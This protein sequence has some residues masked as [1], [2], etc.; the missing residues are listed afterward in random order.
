MLALPAAAQEIVPTNEPSLEVNLDVIDGLKPAAP[1]A[2]PQPFMKLEG[3]EPGPQAKRPPKKK[4][5]PVPAKKETPS[6]VPAPLEEEPV[7]PAPVQ[8]EA[9][10]PEPVVEA[11]QPEPQPA[12]EPEKKA[13][14]KS[15]KKSK[16]S[17][18][19]APAEL[20]NPFDNP[21]AVPA[22]P[23]AIPAPEPEKKSEKKTEKKAEDVKPQEPL[24]SP[25]MLP[26]PVPQPVEPQPEPVVTPEPKKPGLMERFRKI[27]GMDKKVPAPAPIPAPEANPAEP[28]PIPE[29]EPAAQKAPEPEMPVALPPVAPPIP[30][31]PPVTNDLAALPEEPVEKVKEK[32]PE[33]EKAPVLA[34]DGLPEKL[35]PLNLAPAEAKVLATIDFAA[36]EE[37]PDDLESQKVREAAKKM[38][39]SGEGRFNLMA[40]AATNDNDVGDARRIALKRGIAVRKLLVDAGFASERLNVQALGDKTQSPRRD[41]VDIVPLD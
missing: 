37:E 18:K 9:V 41:R 14:K 4:K 24:P 19:E 40:Y 20:G 11:P 28:A 2:R 34:A 15:E 35:P 29:P 1:E 6:E 27:I 10:K 23:E 38:K 36:G 39:A 13:E 12:P 32:A 5:N 16:K 7:Q 31:A 26:A 25:E 8:P 17:K 21:N 33:K 30:P 22:L 3:P